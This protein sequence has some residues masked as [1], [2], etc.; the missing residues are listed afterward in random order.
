MLRLYLILFFI[1]VLNISDA[2]KK[3]SVFCHNCHKHVSRA[4]GS[5]FPKEK[6]TTES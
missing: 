4:H 1:L 2:D 6:N 3:C 5:L